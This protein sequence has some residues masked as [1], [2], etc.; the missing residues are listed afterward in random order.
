MYVYVTRSPAAA[1]APSR[2]GCRVPRLPRPT[3]VSWKV[4][5]SERLRCASQGVPRTPAARFL[6]RR[7]VWYQ[8]SDQTNAAT[9]A[10]PSCA[11]F[12]AA[13]RF[14]HAQNRTTL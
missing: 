6:A 7:H 1:G 9:D 3:G 10:G 8:R 11:T 5:R 12:A 13:G 14:I 4:L 2:A